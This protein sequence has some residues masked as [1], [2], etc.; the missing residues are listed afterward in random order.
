MNP[1]LPALLLSVLMSHGASAARWLDALPADDPDVVVRRT[2][3]VLE[4]IR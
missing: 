1:L 3:P 2:A 4:K